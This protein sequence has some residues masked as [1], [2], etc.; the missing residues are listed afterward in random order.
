MPAKN[1]LK[2]YV[3]NSFYHIYN[4]GVEKRT[5]FQDDQDYRVFL[6]YLK[7]YLSPP[8]SLISYKGVS[9]VR[10]PRQRSLNNFHK[11]ISLVT[12]CLMPNH[13]HLLVKQ[14]P[15]NG[16]EKFMRSLGTKYV[17]YFNKRHQRIGPL[18]QNTYKAVL[19]ETDEQLLHLSRYI[20]LNPVRDNDKEN[21]LRSLQKNLLNNYSSYPEYLGKRKTEWVQ[22]KEIL[23]F[24]KTAH[25]TTLKD[26][27]SYQ[28]FVEDY[29]QSSGKILQGLVLE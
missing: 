11:K 25:K 22:P 29:Q 6:H 4:R 13:F 8:E 10:P 12:Y 15:S 27:L 24:F 28:S 3:E 19:I 26:I 7:I 17:Q 23:N 16:I 1:T 9:F 21:S 14:K 18:F 5:I 20:H 2:P